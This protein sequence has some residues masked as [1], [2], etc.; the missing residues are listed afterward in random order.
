MHEMAIAQSLLALAEEEATRRSLSRLEHI[1][2]QWGALCGVA[3]DALEFC[4]TALTA[5]GPHAACKL[6]LE[7]QPLRL[8]CVCGQ[9]FEAGEVHDLAGIAAQGLFLSP[10]PACGE[11][12]GHE[13]LSGRE[14]I[15]KAIEAS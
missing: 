13:V 1:H 15:L 2:V 11:E 9:L 12:F 5:T 10:C 7:R 3:P 14:L 4:F 8:R 6:S